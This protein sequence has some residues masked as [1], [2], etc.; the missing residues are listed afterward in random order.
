[1]ITLPLLEIPAPNLPLAACAGM[2]AEA[3]FPETG[4]DGRLAKEICAY[5]PEREACLRWAFETREPFGIYGGM[6][7]HE[8]RALLRYRSAA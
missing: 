1:M 7:A 8:R 3:W 5:C 2:D 6:S 4:G